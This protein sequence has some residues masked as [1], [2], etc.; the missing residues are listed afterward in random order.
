[1]TG[2]YGGVE[3]IPIFLSMHRYP[4]SV[5]FKCATANC[6]RHFTKKHWTWE[7]RSSIRHKG[8]PWAPCF[9][10]L[11][12]TGLSFI[13]CDEIEAWKPSQEERMLFL[14]KRNWCGQDP[15]P[16]AEEERREIVF[17]ILHRWT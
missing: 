11:K 12:K 10:T 9:R 4:V 5:V 16:P 14:G 3:Y 2:H 1:V 15:Q 13:E 8:K 17:G 6:R 7:S